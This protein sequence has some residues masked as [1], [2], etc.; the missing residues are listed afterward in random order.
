MLWSITTMRSVIPVRLLQRRLG[1]SVFDP[2]TKLFAGPAYTI[3]SG[4]APP[5]EPATGTTWR[6][7]LPWCPRQVLVHF[8]SF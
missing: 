7:R 3:N 5:A 2:G 1:L 4:T 8:G 6:S